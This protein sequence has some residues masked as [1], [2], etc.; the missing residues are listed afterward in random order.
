MGADDF[1]RFTERKSTRL[2]Y[3]DERRSVLRV[4][5]KQGDLR[6]VKRSKLE[7]AVKRCKSPDESCT[8]RRVPYLNPQ[9]TEVAPKGA[10]LHFLISSKILIYLSVSFVLSIPK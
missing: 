1:G 8:A 4:N 6:T 5:G 9:D 2:T 10:C 3:T 7:G